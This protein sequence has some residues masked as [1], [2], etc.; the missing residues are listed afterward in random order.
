MKWSPSRTILFV[1]NP[2]AGLFPTPAA[3]PVG[4]AAFV[5]DDQ[6]AVTASS[7]L[8]TAY[9]PLLVFEQACFG[10]S[11]SFECVVAIEMVRRDIQADTD[12]RAKLVDGFEL[13]AGELQ[14]IPLVVS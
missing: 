12:I 10:I 1:L 11:V 8:S 9:E 7:A 3:E 5:R 4:F 2:D 6:L 14:N 13:E